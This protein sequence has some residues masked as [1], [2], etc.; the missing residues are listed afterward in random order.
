MSILKTTNSG[1][2]VIPVTS[3]QEILDEIA[4]LGYSYNYT[5]RCWSC[6]KNSLPNI[7]IARFYGLNP[8]YIY[9]NFSTSGST[10]YTIITMY[11]LFNFIEDIKRK[12]VNS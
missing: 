8:F 7:A 6:S 2:K 10:T 12:Y 5:L 11:D 9:V 3:E 1:S 4:K